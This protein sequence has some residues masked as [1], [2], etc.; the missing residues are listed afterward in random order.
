V[1][2]LSD[3]KKIAVVLNKQVFDEHYK[4]FMRQTQ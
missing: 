1:T 4:L 2:D 3:N